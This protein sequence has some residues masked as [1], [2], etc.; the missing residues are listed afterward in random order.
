MDITQNIETLLEQAEEDSN[1]ESKHVFKPRFF[2]LF[3]QNQLKHR[4]YCDFRSNKIIDNE[5]AIKE[6]NLKFEKFCPEFIFIGSK[7][8]ISVVLQDEII[9]L[10]AIKQCIQVSKDILRK[11]LIFEQEIKFTLFEL[12]NDKVEHY[13]KLLEEML[14]SVGFKSIKKNSEV[15][16]TGKKLNLLVA[17]NLNKNCETFPVLIIINSWSITLRCFFCKDAK[18]YSYGPDEILEKLELFL[19]KINPVLN[20][21]RLL[22]DNIKKCTVLETSF[23]TKDLHDKEIQRLFIMA[24]YKIIENFN[25]ISPFINKIIQGKVVEESHAILNIA[26]QNKSN[27]KDWI[28]S[29]NH[30][31]INKALYPSSFKLIN[32][33][34]MHEF[35]KELKILELLSPLHLSFWHI[36]DEKSLAIYYPK[37]YGSKVKKKKNLSK[38]IEAKLIDFKLKLLETLSNYGNASNV[39]D[40]IYLN[41]TDGANL[42]Y[43]PAKKIYLLME[44]DICLDKSTY[45]YNENI[46]NHLKD[47]LSKIFGKVEINLDDLD[48]FNLDQKEAVF[49]GD[50]YRII[51]FFEFYEQEGRCGLDSLNF[52]AWFK[53]N[54]RFLL[55]VV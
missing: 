32:Y 27:P 24:F 21:I 33:S 45:M 48:S 41:E 15:C 51:D 42:F 19:L 52:I 54:E 35:L 8:Y 23:I 39:F 14:E 18:P 30:E 12:E 49:I 47:F 20:N 43:L 53:Y 44:N 36:I 34:S 9:T 28:F 38:K 1:H 6:L 2:K 3:S 31:K 37:F 17:L 46:E 29:L 50:R 16:M 26:N 13:L 10:E 4:L 40:Q 11:I 22:T 25:K 55:L 7:K 5:A